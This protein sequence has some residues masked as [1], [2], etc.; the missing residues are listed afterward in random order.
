MKVAYIRV[1]TEEQNTARQ[2][3]S[4]AGSRCGAF[5]VKGVEERSQK[6]PCQSPPGNTHELG[7]KGD[8]AGVLDQCDHG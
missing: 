2:E 1:S 4:P 7:N 8:I 5:P 3:G 6:G